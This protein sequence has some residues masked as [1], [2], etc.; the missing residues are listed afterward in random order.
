MVYIYTFSTCNGGFSDHD[1][2]NPVV[3]CP[4]LAPSVRH[5]VPCSVCVLSVFCLCSVCVLTHDMTLPTCLL[6]T[7]NTIPSVHCRQANYAGTKLS[8]FV[9]DMYQAVCACC[10]S[11]F[12]R[13]NCSG[14]MSL[15]LRKPPDFDEYVAIIQNISGRHI[16]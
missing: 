16:G 3:Y 7:C 2:S 13:G 9:F 4:K 15:I 1:P 5:S 6:N 12:I 11:C 14:V 10:I 8:F